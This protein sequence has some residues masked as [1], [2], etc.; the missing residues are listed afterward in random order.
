MYFALRAPTG[1]TGYAI[2]LKA[3]N[4]ATVVQTIALAEEGT[5]GEFFPASAITVAAGKYRIVVTKDS[6][7]L[8]APENLFEW[9]GTS[10]IDQ[11]YLANAIASI[12]GGGATATEIA[13]AVWSATGGRS[14]TDKAGFA[15]STAGITAIVTAVWGATTKELTGF[16]SL[17]A[18]I[19]TAVWNFATRG[20]TLAVVTDAASRTASKADL[21]PLQTAIAAIPT[22]PLLASN[23]IAPD[24][25]TKIADLH[26][27]ITALR[28]AKLDTVAVLANAD[29]FKANVTALA[30]S[31][32]LSSVSSLVS[33]IPTNPL[34]ASNYTSPNN[35]GIASINSTLNGLLAVGGTS[36]STAALQN[37][38]NGGA[39]GLTTEQNTRLFQLPLNNNLVTADLNVIT[40]AINSSKSA[41][42]A[43][44]AQSWKTATGFNTIIPDNAGITSLL[45]RLTT[46]RAAKLDLALSTFNASADSVKV[47]AVGSTTVSSAND[48][49]ATIPVNLATATNVTA[50]RDAV[51]AVGNSGWA[52][53]EVDLTATNNSIGALQVTANQI[54][55]AAF[56]PASQSVSLN[57]VNGQPVTIADFRANVSTLALKTDL[58]PLAL[59]ADV[60]S[61][62]TLLSG[63]L[64]PEAT[65][66]K[67]AALANAPKGTGLTTQQSQQLFS[68][69]TDNNLAAINNALTTAKNEILGDSVDIGSV[70]GVT[71]S[72]LADFKANIAPVLSAVQAIP[73]NRS[74]L[75]TISSLTT[76]GS[77]RW[78]AWCKLVDSLSSL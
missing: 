33:A 73:T 52:K 64:T 63:L 69:A 19:A 26:D 40:G 1:G 7:F 8:T 75:K 12:S 67:A 4:S 70:N 38:P 36:F 35:S 59:K 13:S 21:S 68:I 2:Q 14:L 16:G 49:K 48:L 34:L 9:N 24:N 61:V 37:A 46:T 71:V 6:A 31:A 65:A 47:G 50:A 54:A 28:A 72:S 53:T 32:G 58:S 11:T 76:Q 22:N 51:I 60:A 29:S 23:Y 30:T 3:V 39:A 20:L 74:L 57:R 44:G 77:A 66:F 55:A 78:R 18:D 10:P 62:S 43:E 56:N 5:S 25:S 41:I 17:V 27:R 15:L 42:L 45:S